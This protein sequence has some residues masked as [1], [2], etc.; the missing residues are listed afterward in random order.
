MDE[1]RK[2]FLRKKSTSG[3]DAVKIIGMTAK[4][5]EYSINVVD[6]AGAGSEMIS[7][8]FERSSAVG[9][10]LSN[11]ITCYREIIHERKSR[12]QRQT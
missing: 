5:L 4:A 3:E 11:R 7:F 1:R 6:K 10:M 8:C 2:W 12:L 9:K